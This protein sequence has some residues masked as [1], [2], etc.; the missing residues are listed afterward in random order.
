MES[1]RKAQRRYHAKNTQKCRDMRN[2]WRARQAIKMREIVKEAKS[3]PCAECGV[4]YPHYV[5]DLD[6]RDPANKDMSVANMVG[7]QRSLVR[8]KKEI[9]KCDVVCS[10]CHR[11]RTYNQYQ[12]REGKPW[13]DR[14]LEQVA[15]G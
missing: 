5:M 10:N 8:L 1:R 4:E 2:N 6:H 15:A 12:A 7:Q 3:V 9:A 13:Y 14:C 11:V